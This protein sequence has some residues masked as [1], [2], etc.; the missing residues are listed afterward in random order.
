MSNQEI[1]PQDT[2]NETEKEYSRSV[3]CGI[4]GLRNKINNKWYIGQTVQPFR[5]RWMVYKRLHC[6]HQPK[7][8]AALTKYG[9][10][11]F[12]KIIL[13]LCP[14]DENILN[15]KET[16]WITDKDSVNN[17]YNII[18]IGGTCGMLG[19]SHTEETKIKMSNAKRGKPFSDSHKKGISNG[20]VLRRL[21]P[22]GGIPESARKKISASHMGKSL[23]EEHK[24]KLRVPKS[25][26]HRRKIADANRI[27][28]AKNIGKKLSDSHK[29]NLKDAWKKRKETKSLLQ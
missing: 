16:Y 29:Q 19:K 18:A 20:W 11:N 12:E 7:L 17:G 8:L 1:V 22:D 25:P 15:T 23:S 5:D 10:N 3:C 2:I 26:E 27:K 21:R 4:Y 24:E 13:E 6:Y 14:R 9:Y 28:N